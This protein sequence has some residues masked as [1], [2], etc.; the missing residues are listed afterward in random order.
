LRPCFDDNDLCSAGLFIL[1]CG[2]SDAK[3]SPSGATTFNAFSPE[4]FFL[5]FLE[6]AGGLNSCLSSEAASSSSVL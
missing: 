2:F 5:L 4:S 1:V 3:A 6:L